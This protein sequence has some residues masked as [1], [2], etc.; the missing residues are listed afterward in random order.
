MNKFLAIQADY[1]NCA[2]RTL[3]TILLTDKES[4]SQ[5]V[6]YIYNYEG[7]HF[8]IFDNIFEVVNFFNNKPYQLLEEYSN[9][10]NIDIFLE[11]YHF[12]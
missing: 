4:K 7:V 5:K 12:N 8:R 1:I 9:E 6:V 10:E 2:S 3:E 11:N